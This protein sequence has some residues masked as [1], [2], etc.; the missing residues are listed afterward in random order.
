M[1]QPTLKRKKIMKL[2]YKNRKNSKASVEE[3]H[4]R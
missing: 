3:A 2:C 4:F 1:Y